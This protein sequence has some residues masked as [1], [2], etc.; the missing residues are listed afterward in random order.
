M[1]AT[2]VSIWSFLACWLRVAIVR[3]SVAEIY[4]SAFWMVRSAR[5]LVA[6]NYGSAFWMARSARWWTKDIGDSSTPFAAVK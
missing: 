3:S 5:S 6:E 4:G 2:L 1:E